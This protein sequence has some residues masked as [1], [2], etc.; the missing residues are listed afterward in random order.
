MKDEPATDK[1]QDQLLFQHKDIYG[2]DFAA[3]S[4]HFS[5]IKEVKKRNKHEGENSKFIGSMCIVIMFS[6]WEHYYRG[7]IAKAYGSPDAKN[8]HDDFWGDMRRLRNDIVHNKSKCKESENTK[9][10]CWFKK[11][12][13]IVITQNKMRNVFLE[14]LKYRNKLYKDSLSKID[15]KIPFSEVPGTEH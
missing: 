12:E 10:L 3:S 11:N 6:Y 2:N 14:A 9:L 7:K 8:I 4:I 13:D 15:K 5:K 1:L